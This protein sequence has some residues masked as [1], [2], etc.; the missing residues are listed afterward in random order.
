MVWL[1]GRA[2]NDFDQ[3]SHP[4]ATTRLAAILIELPGL[5]RIGD[6][7]SHDR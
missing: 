5:V 2:T 6:G 1:A 7:F 4:E 3:K